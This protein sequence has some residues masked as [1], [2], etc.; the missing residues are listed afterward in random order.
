MPLL[1]ELSQSPVWIVVALIL[2]LSTFRLLKIIGKQFEAV[3]NQHE[4]FDFQNR[5]TWQDIYRQLPDYTPASKRL[6]TRFFIADFFFPFC[7]SL[8]LS[9]LWTAIFQRPDAPVFNQLLAWGV[10]LLAF[11]PTVFDW[12]ENVF[13]LILVHLYPKQS[14]PLAR[15]GVVCKRLKLLSLVLTL[16]GTMVWIALGLLSAA[17]V[18]IL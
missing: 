12:G 15:V 16:G 7:A 13:F 11:S 2:Q 17:W 1:I 5:L 9:L 8:F 3:T 18:D 6:Y 14:V 10:P 4:V